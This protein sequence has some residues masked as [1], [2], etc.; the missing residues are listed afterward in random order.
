M[1]IWIVAALA[2]LLVVILAVGWRRISILRQVNLEGLEDDKVAQA[3]NR[4]SQWP[5]F[6]FL[7]LMVVREIG[8]YHPEGVI[9]DIGCGPGYLVAAI[10]KSFPNIRIIGVDISKEMVQLATDSAYSLSLSEQVQFRQGDVKELPFQDNS[11]DF[12]VSTLSLH[13]WTEPRQALEEIHRILR[14]GGQFLIFDLRRDVR[15]LFYWLVCFAQRCVVPA[16]LRKINEPTGSV[17]SSY[18]AR[19]AEAI[20]S[21]MS[22]QQYRIKPGFGWIFIWGRK[23]G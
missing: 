2:L 3:Y 4:I 18:T 16:A 23:G 9:V 21:G 12:A 10:A 11:V 5:Q 6:R 22:F 13:H 8:R 14:T 19:E 17:R 15:Q 7:R 20:L 1:W